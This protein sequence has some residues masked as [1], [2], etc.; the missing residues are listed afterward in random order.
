M[1]DCGD[2]NRSYFL[3]NIKED[4]GRVI[5]IGIDRATPDQESDNSRSLT[6]DDDDTSSFETLSA[7]WMEYII[8]T[9]EMVPM[10]SL[11][12]HEIHTQ[13]VESNAKAYIQDRGNLLEEK[14]ERL[15]NDDGE[16][17]EKIYELPSSAL[18]PLSAKL[19]SANRS[20]RIVRIHRSSQI[21]S[22][23][24]Q[25]EAV[26]SDALRKAIGETPRA[27]ISKDSVIA[28]TAV[29]LSEDI[30][31]IKRQI[32]EEKVDKIS[33]NSH[34]NQIEDIEKRLSLKPL[35][36][37]L[38]LKFVEVCERRNLLTHAGGV[39]NAR[40]LDN[41]KAKGYSCK[42]LPEIGQAIPISTPYIMHAA[43]T[44]ALVGLFNIHRIWRKLRPAESATSSS[45]LIN[46]SHEFLIAEEYEIAKAIAKF[47]LD[48]CENVTESERA[49]AVI[50][51][52]LSFFL[53]ESIPPDKRREKTEDALS[54]RD[55]SI[56]DGKFAL[57]ICCLREEYD[58][59]PARIDGAVR[60]EIGAEQFETWALFKQVRKLDLFRHKM[61]EHFGEDSADVICLNVGTS[62]LEHETVV[63]ESPSD[64][65]K[66]SVSS[67]KNDKAQS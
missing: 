43:E 32:V 10:L 35:S 66:N 46:A 17:L 36:Q 9:I 30:Q 54:L 7:T 48:D 65:T 55:W 64:E 27:F 39:V 21:L 29:I 38:M 12:A 42:D 56:L 22:L 59:L 2:Q 41:L 1:P 37:A 23:I 50:N 34:A 6:P 11:V 47:I 60:D 14:I 45:H 63:H 16:L 51:L 25:Y 20:L 4:N 61:A 3:A 15:E 31:S 44:V 52:S 53:D 40:Y 5:K 58:K 26:F 57:A 33:R 8:G 28:A 67:Q 62:V 24:S 13:E 49:F 18:G 19:K